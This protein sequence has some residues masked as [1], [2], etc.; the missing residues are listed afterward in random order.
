MPYLIALALG[1]LSA[2]GGT[3]YYF[4]N[5][6][7][8]LGALP[9][10][11]SGQ[12][13]A[14]AENGDCLTTDGSANAWGDCGG[15][16]SGEANTASSLGTGRNIFDSKSS[17][18]LR[19]NTLAAGTNV[20]LST[21]S[22]ANTIVISSTGGSGGSGT[23]S[24]S[25]NETAGR[26]SYWT[27]NS[28]TPALLGEV[29]TT[30]LTAS[31]PL[32]LSNP[33]AKV[34]GSNSILTI[35]TSGTWSGNAGTATAL[36]ANGSNC[37]AGSYALGVDASGVAEGCTDATTEIDSAISTHTSNAN[38]HH[39]AVTLAGSLDY[40]T[41]SGQQI[42][43]NAIDLA[44]D[45]TGDLPFSNLAQLTAGTVLANPTASTA[46]GQAVATSTLFGANVPYGRILFSNGS[47]WAATAT[48]SLFSDSQ[49]LSLWLSDETGTG[50]VVYGTSPTISSPTISSFFG[51]AC[52]GNEFLQDI[53]DDGTFTCAA[54]SGGGSPFPFTTTGYGVS[55]STTIGFTNGLLSTASSTFTANTYFPG[56]GIWNSSG[57]VGI[58]TPTPTS[59]L[60][61][62]G[63]ETARITAAAEVAGNDYGYVDVALSLNNASA[64]TAQVK[65]FT[66]GSEGFYS[67][68]GV[69]SLYDFYIYD[70][71]ADQYRLFIDTAGDVGFGTT[72]PTYKLSVEGSSTLGNVARAGYFIATTTTP[73][74]FPYAST[75]ALSATSLCLTN[76]CR[77][78]WPASGA[79]GDS[80]FFAS[81][82]VATDVTLVYNTDVG[83]DMA[84]GCSTSATST[85]PFWLDASAAQ[86]RVGTTTASDSAIQF[87]DN[88]NDTWTVGYDLTNSNFVI[89]SSTDLGTSNAL[90]IAK[91][92]NAITA[93]GAL[94]VTG[95]LTASANFV[96]DGQTFDSFTD[97]ATLSNNSGDLQVV[98]VTC[99]D[100]LNATEIE[101]IYLLIAGDTSS[102]NYTMT[103]T[104]DIGGG[105]LEIPN[106]TGPTADDPGELAHDTTTNTL[107]LDDF[108]VGKS[109]NK[110]WGATIASTSPAF[111]SGS[112]L[113]VPT[114][115]SGYTI[116]RIQ[117]H[118]TS[119]TSKVI[120]VEDASAN[121]SED[122]T[123]ATTNTT[124]D[125]SITNATYTASELSYIDFGAT[126]GSVDY[127][128]IS[129]FGTW[130]RD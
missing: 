65:L 47:S 36:A 108:V 87:N 76:D 66:F 2:V 25:T 112:L 39:N 30:T 64:S 59:L 99:T 121:S 129:V 111:I 122:I 3:A 14:D 79:G 126:S 128:T 96:F 117:C 125:G 55:T 115:L 49:D 27:S 1:F 85:C 53:G 118:V 16:G 92:T 4:Q 71:V 19:F 97:D 60:T 51:T 50:V 15:I 93:G 107:I 69:A 68:A 34:G 78:T 11:A 52:T 26:L 88:D 13:A 86:L 9:F 94:T 81:T 22:N 31:S 127:V 89:S 75:T 28:G 63:N 6:D 67:D 73:S 90:S 95:N 48:T 40:L 43:R 57:S 7:P 61:V 33:V 106:G 32:S 104:W 58:G 8:T 41:L 74:S 10:I 103:G 91:G 100:C 35:D 77:T 123:C 72:S 18:D 80:L 38:A 82:T 17:V 116:T 84:F 102:G 98:D 24:T 130:T 12:L 120:A 105:V 109:V 62:L 101:D 29:A 119:G 83:A 5:S 54:A 42:T 110:I 124:D 114:Q 113:A 21:T 70:E 37:S 56:S 20:T 44:T 46:D 23:V 45:V